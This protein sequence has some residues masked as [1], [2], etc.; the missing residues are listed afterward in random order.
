[1]YSIMHKISFF[2]MYK[3]KTTDPFVST[4]ECMWIG[5]LLG[6]AATPQG[7]DFLVVDQ[8]HKASSVSGGV[9]QPASPQR[10]HKR[11]NWS[12]HHILI[13]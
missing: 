1:M 7:L 2:Y 4:E 13:L 8:T 11:V 3:S 10:L 9:Q 12:V 6:F 5:P